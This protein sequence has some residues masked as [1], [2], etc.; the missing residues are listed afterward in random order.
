MA[1]IVTGR[2]KNLEELRCLAMLMV[3]VLH[4]LGKGKLL[5][6]PSNAE[7]S[8]VNLVAWGIEAFCIVAVNVYMLISGYVLCES[9]FKLKRALMLY[10]QI[11]MY[12]V[13]V[14]IVAALTGLVPAAEVDTH[15]YLSLLFPI[16]M[17]H[18]WFMTAYFVL[19]LML[20][21][22]T[23]AVNRMSKEWLK[24]VLIML[25]GYFCVLKSI[26]PV[27]L[28]QDGMGYDVLWYLCLFLL[29]AY[30]R[31]YGIP[32]LKSRLVCVAL[33]V[34]GCVLAFAELMCLR[35][36]YLSGGSFGLIMKISFEYNHIFVLMASVGLFGLFL[37]GDGEHFLGRFFSGLAPFVLGVYLLHENIGVRYGWQILFG[38]N[39]I[40]SIPELV[41]KTVLAAMTVFVLGIAVEWLRV[42]I[43]KLIGKLLGLL[44]C[45]CRLVKKVEGVEQ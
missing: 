24:R 11:W 21:L 29:A 19:Y 22:L 40:Q 3:V 9:S 34:G 36:L 4:F 5:G 26:L 23:I 31:K 30:I 18:Y 17:G 35:T 32:F 15:Y 2:K 33:Y 25:L 37:T 10:L 38:V 8:A 13:G 20:P 27:R 7:M 12:S 1:Q 41:W 28:E 45:W 6:D 16:S 14:G 44:P 42:Q 39:R 43:V